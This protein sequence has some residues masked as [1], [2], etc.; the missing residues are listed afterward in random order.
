MMIEAANWVV[1]QL[2][3]TDKC[4]SC[5]LDIKQFGQSAMD[6]IQ[7]ITSFLSILPLLMSLKINSPPIYIRSASVRVGCQ[8]LQL[9]SLSLDTLLDAQ[10]TSGESQEFDCARLGLER[11]LLRAGS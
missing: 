6:F 4:N 10:G 1:W 11:L 5:T 7:R 3:G 9:N 8:Q 2:T